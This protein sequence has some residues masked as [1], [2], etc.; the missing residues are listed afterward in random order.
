MDSSLVSK[1][2]AFWETTQLVNVIIDTTKAAPF[3]IRFDEK[4]QIFRIHKA[5]PLGFVFPFNLGFVPSTRGGDGDA[6]D[7]LILTDHVLPIGCVVLGE[8][9][10]VLEATQIEGPQKQR[11]DRLI[12]IPIELVSRKPMLPE[13]IFDKNLRAAI[14]KFFIKYNELQ[15]R[16][17]RPLRYRPA[18]HAVAL[19]REHAIDNRTNSR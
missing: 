12:A 19:V 13:V 1:L 2:P 18:S 4:I 5:M 8:L 14:S 16:V 9:V 6:L 7:V 17:F 15:G 10:A 11:N 3:K